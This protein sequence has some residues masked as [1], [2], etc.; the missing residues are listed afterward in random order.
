MP[1]NGS[2]MGA[3]KRTAAIQNS[4]R[5]PAI[6]VWLEHHVEPRQ[7]HDHYQWGLP[8]P[9]IRWEWALMVGIT[10]V[11]CFFLNALAVDAL[12]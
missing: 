1:K 3:N 10:C 7:T 5:N 12:S 11:V 6:T 9:L 4:R 2:Q 8:L